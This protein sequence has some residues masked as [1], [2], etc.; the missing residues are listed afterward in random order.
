MASLK[1]SPSSSPS[2]PEEL[3]VVQVLNSCELLVTNSSLVP[4]VQV[5]DSNEDAETDQRP[6]GSSGRRV[7]LYAGEVRVQWNLK[8]VFNTFNTVDNCITFAAARGMI[9]TTKVCSYHRSP[10]SLF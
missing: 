5:L 8:K 4:S 6:S 1:S 10:M 3:S 7:Q 2:P 9:P